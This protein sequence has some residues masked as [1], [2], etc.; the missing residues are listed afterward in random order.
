MPRNCRAEREFVAT[1][2]PLLASVFEKLPITRSTFPSIFCMSICP[3]PPGPAA[4]KSWAMS[5]INTAPCS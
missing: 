2:P 3:V 1:K 5:I 4:P